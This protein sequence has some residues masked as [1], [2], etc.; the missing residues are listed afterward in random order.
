ME[1]MAF[2]CGDGMQIYRIIRYRKQEKGN[3]SF[4]RGGINSL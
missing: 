3:L 2:R 4:G 1:K